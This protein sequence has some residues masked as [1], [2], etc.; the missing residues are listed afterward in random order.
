MY[1]DVKD[2]GGSRSLMIPREGPSAGAMS[3]GGFRRC[4]LVLKA[5]A[6]LE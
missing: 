6:G 1:A 4:D 2:A 3:L 5:G